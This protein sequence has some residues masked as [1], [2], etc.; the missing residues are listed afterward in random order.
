MPVVGIPACLWRAFFIG[1]TIFFWYP[2]GM[3]AGIKIFTSDLYWRQIVSEWGAVVVDNE[4]IADVNLDT[5]G[6]HTPV[7]AVELKSTIIG[8]M[9]NTDVVNRVFGRPVQL[10][11]IQTDIVARLA[12]T[13]GMTAEELKL[14]LGYAPDATTHTVE[15]AIY[16]LRKLFGHDFIKN[17]DGKF[18]IG[19]I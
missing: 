1:H 13:G 17:Q 11:P 6:L 8:A 12:R 19:N 18:V 3:L 15:T 14:A 2:G 9:D 5:L 10:S 4:K 7:S 16:G